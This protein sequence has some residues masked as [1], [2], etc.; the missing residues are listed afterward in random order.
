[1]RKFG[2]VALRVV[3]QL[4]AYEEPYVGLTDFPAE[5]VAK[6]LFLGSLEV[7][8]PMVLSK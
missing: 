1:M 5:K 4:R 6:L 7:S 3:E 2:E 8:R